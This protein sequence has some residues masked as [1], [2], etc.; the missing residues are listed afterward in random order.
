MSDRPSPRSPRRPESIILARMLLEARLAAGLTQLEA[1][2]ELGVAQTL[3]SKIEVNERKVEL[4]VVRDL[5]RIY[6]VDFIDFVSRLDKAARKGKAALRPRLVRKDK[7][8]SRA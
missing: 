3:I 6:G 7:G 1:A 5:C 8:T 2:S 4:V